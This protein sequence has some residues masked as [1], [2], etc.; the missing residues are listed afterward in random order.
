M[1]SCVLVRSTHHRGRVTSGA[2]VVRRLSSQ[3]ML[4]PRQGRATGGGCAALPS[5]CSLGS[6]LPFSVVECGDGWGLKDPMVTSAVFMPLLSW[7]R[8]RSCQLPTLVCM[9]CEK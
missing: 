7:A 9:L 5:G 2:G 8:T 1:L 4:Q 6:V 3:G